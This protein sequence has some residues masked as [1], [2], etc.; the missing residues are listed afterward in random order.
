MGYELWIMG[1]E[2]WIMSYGL[3]VMNYGLWFM[4][5]GLWVMDYEFKLLFNVHRPS[6]IAHRLKYLSCVCIGGYEVSGM[7]LKH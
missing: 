3:W 6:P 4:N 7:S 1:Y 5:Y 2:L